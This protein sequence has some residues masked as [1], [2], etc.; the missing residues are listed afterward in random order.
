MGLQ[1]KMSEDLKTALKAG[2]DF[3]VGVLRYLQAAL[4]NSEIEK[5][6]KGQD[7]VL[8]DEEVIDVLSR[9]AKKR[10]EAVAAYQKGNRA[11]L[12][13]KET[14]EHELITRYLPTQLSKGEI[15]RV[16]I[17]VIAATGA[18]VQKDFGRVMGEAIKKMKGRVDAKLVSEIIKE[19]L[20]RQ[21]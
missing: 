16:V 19:M 9:E 15:E 17:E 13:E 4:H 6:G 3:D 5:K 8:I 12:A 18:R 7:A 10:K 11:D 2:R 20:S 21:E 14:K 1:Q